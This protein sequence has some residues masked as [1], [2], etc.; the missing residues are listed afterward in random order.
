MSILGYDCDA[1]ISTFQNNCKTLR[2]IDPDNKHLQLIVFD[3]HGGALVKSEFWRR[4]G[5]KDKKTRHY[6]LHAFENANKKLEAAIKE[7]KEKGLA[8]K[9][10]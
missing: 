1:E 4:Y 9:I 2:K 7:A 8:S 10:D 5:P 6:G 3:N